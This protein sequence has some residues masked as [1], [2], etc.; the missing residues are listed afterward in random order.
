MARAIA[1]IE[2]APRS[3]FGTLTLAPEQHFRL[4]ALARQ[5]CAKQSLDWSSLDDADQFKEVCRHLVREVQL[6]WKRLRKRTGSKFRYLVAIERHKSG[7]PHV[8]LLLH[9]VR[10]PV[11]WAELSAAWPLGFSH[12]KLV[13]ERE[14]AKAA[15]YVSKY[16]TKANSRMI[17]SAAYGATDRQEMPPPP[18]QKNASQAAGGLL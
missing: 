5:S 12:F 13:A 4:V 16:L 14:A 15:V 9:E 1:E 10:G 3:W 2:Q 17:A 18:L 8:H 6:F 11:R 7:A